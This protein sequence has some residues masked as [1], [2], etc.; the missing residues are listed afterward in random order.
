MSGLLRRLFAP[1]WQHPDPEV[2]RQAVARL[3]LARD[4]HRLTLARLARDE[5]PSVRTAAL[6]RLDD[7][8]RLLDLFDEGDASEELSRRLIALLT[9]RS[10]SLELG[11]RIALIE[12]LDDA[13]LLAE[14][15]LQGDNQQLRLAALARLDGEEALIRQACDNGIAAVRHAAAER[16]MSEAGLARLAQQARRDRQVMRQARE[17]LNRLRADAAQLAAARERREALLTDLERQATA[18]WEPLYAGR[19]RH[20]MREWTAL[21]DLPDASQE[22]RYHDACLRCRKVI[23]DH[24]ARQRASKAAETRREDAEQAREA[25][26]EAL[27]EGLEALGRSEEVMPQDIASLRAQKQLLAHRWQ[28]LSEQHL[29]DPSLRQRYDAVR[30]GFERISQAWV[31][32]EERA[33]EVE[34]ALID[35]DDERL[36]ALLDA[37]AWPRQLAPAPLL[38]RARDRLAQQEAPAEDQAARLARFIADLD[39]LESLLERGA[40]KGASRLYQRLRQ[41]ADEVDASA[42]QPHAAR[43]RQLGA[44][45]AELR[46]WRSFVAGPKRDQLVQAIEALAED[47]SLVDAGLDRRHRQLVKEWKSLGDAAANREQA[48]RFRAASYRIHARLAP[49]RKHLDAERQANLVTR[50]TLCDQLETLLDQPAEEADPD[51]LREIR[52]RARDQWRRAAPVPRDQAEVIGRRFGRIRHALQALIDQRAQAVAETKRDLIEQVRA[53]LGQ[54][55]PAARRAEAVKSLQQRWRELGRAPRGEE[56]ALWREFR[57]LCDQVFASREA[58]RDDRVRQARERQ[59]AMQTL[60]E[61]MDAWHPVSSIDD[62]VLATAIA[63]ASALEPLP[64]GRR[65]EGMRRRWSGIVRARRERLERLAVVEEVE[66]WRTVQPLLLAHLEAD[67]ERLAGGEPREVALPEGLRLADDMRGAHARRNAARQAP[68]PGEEMDEQLARVRVHLSLLAVGSVSHRDDPLRLAIQ[69]ERLNESL[70]RERS[71]AEEVHGVLRELLATGPVA[72]ELWKRE[73]GELDRMLE[74]LTRLPPP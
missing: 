68:P 71:S 54:A 56:Q 3:D 22:R 12:R 8:E 74:R 64:G 57:A 24:E 45:L 19:F 58:E 43:L 26:V 14:L 15:C 28:A 46:D 25:L 9:G 33:D 63:E 31:R 32:L 44:R 7:P 4:E 48:T 21:Q 49:W 61:R 17:R 29:A 38:R 34:R 37:L 69:V 11:T 66:R 55:M 13:V 42:R 62:T 65:T 1:R 23:G 51:A 27:E 53:L 18:P 70:D 40:F 67:A 20:L 60:I 35:G 52:D 5:D 41:A 6:A 50:E 72:P 10:G 39:D 30:E 59:E 2:R 73:V 16:V 47:A 36:A